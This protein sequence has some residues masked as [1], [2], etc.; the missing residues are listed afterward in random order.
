MSRKSNLA[1]EKPLQ[2]MLN[3]DYNYER[4]HNLSRVHLLP[5]MMVN[6]QIPVHREVSQYL[7]HF[8]NDSTFNIPYNRSHTA[9]DVPVYYPP[10]NYHIRYS[11]IQY[12]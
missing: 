12:R 7:G 8:K 3:V 6:T 4:V 11:T 5:R 10:D 1:T 9:Y 2:A